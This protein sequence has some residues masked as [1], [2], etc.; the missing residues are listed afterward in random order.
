M[1]KK[2]DLLKKIKSQLKGR[3]EEII[4][5]LHDLHSQLKSASNLEK[6]N[7][8][9]SSKIEEISVI[10]SD[11]SRK[12]KKSSRIEWLDSD[13]KASARGTGA[14][15]AHVVDVKEYSKLQ[16]KQWNFESGPQSLWL[17]P[18]I[19]VKTRGRTLPGI[20]IEIRSTYATVLF[21]GSEVD[22]KKLALRPADWEN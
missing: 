5:E 2:K 21:G 3:R 18:G 14:R 19:L 12:D 17:K 13:Y 22:I 10:D 15:I 20:V 7:S 11:L 16:K 6:I 1:S 8:E 9:I 4:Q